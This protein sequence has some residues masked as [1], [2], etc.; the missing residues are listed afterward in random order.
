[1]PGHSLVRYN[2][3]Y[4][5]EEVIDRYNEVHEHLL[6]CQRWSLPIEN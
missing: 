6:I 3:V 5:F 1:M 4:I 2:I